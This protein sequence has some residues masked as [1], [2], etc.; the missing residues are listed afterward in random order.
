MI[1]DCDESCF[2]LYRY[3]VWDYIAYI[4]ICIFTK[5][6]GDLGYRIHRWIRKDL[7]EGGLSWL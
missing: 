4:N 3:W 1:M 5:G 7:L 2:L 6:Y